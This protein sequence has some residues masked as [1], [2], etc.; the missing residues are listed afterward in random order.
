MTPNLT[1]TARFLRRLDAG[2]DAWH[3]RTLPGTHDNKR[4]GT[5]DEHAA[6]LA[7]E[8]A[9]GRN[10]F[11][12]VNAG[13]QTGKEI[14]RVRAVFA[15]LD[16]SPLGPILA[17]ALQPHIVVASSP[18]KW[19]VYWI[20]DG[21]PLAQFAGVQRAIAARFGSDATVADLPRLMRL[22]GFMHLKGEPFLSRIE[23]LHDA[24]DYSA[25]QL[26]AEFP[27][28]AKTATAPAPRE[29]GAVVEEGRHD[30]MVALARKLVLSG[31]SGA[32][33]TATLATMADAGRWSR[34]MGVG[35]MARAVAGAV[36]KLGTSGF[37]P[38]TDPADVFGHGELPPG[39][40]PI[41]PA[42][43]FKLTPAAELLQTPKPL[44]WL[45]R[46]YLLPGSCSMLVGEPAA[47][48]SLAVIDW[49][50]CIA[51]GRPW[52]GHRTAPGLVI[53]LAGEGQHGI[54]R[55][56]KAWA[57]DNR[58]DLT[59]A[60]IMVSDRGAALND[61]AALRDVVQ[62]IDA[63]ALLYGPP[64]L[65]VSDTLHRNLAGDEN[66]AKD[67][68][69]YFQAIDTL[70][71]RYGAHILTVHHSGHADSQRA[72][73]SSSLRAAVDT[74]LLLTVTAGAGVR[75]L[76]VTKQKDGPKPAPTHFQLKEVDLPWLTDDGQRETSV[77]LMPASAP[78]QSGW[79]L[80]PAQRRALD[81]L[82][83][84]GKG[85]IPLESWRVKF[86]ETSTADS[87]EAKRQAFHRVRRD[88]VAAGVV[89]CRDDR[90]TVAE[91]VEPAT[92]R[93]DAAEVFGASSM[94]V[95]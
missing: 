22:P 37:E 41:S 54:A 94:T 17:C 4:A 65:I 29:P 18:G 31:L 23:R 67:T 2:N 3:F 69:A 82:A 73:G 88:L 61:P 90:Y 60:S 72:R 63:A 40:S 62:A 51:L 6:W 9:A 89:T 21:L 81:A 20:V 11:A 49:A 79:Q 42:P 36:G 48:K 44:S 38:V 32:E 7:A 85:E 15:D 47:G 35:E 57:V 87:P 71:T 12:V 10:V 68:A 52:R 33:A 77:V 86:Y 27:P 45:L 58:A 43:R 46:D 25:A 84:C 93:V 55:R 56:L 19:H 59:R 83:Q 24:P 39:A 95:H 16:G 13:G 53:Y 66:S 8:N 78:K 70:R 50:A 1:D 76:A 34:E 75:T 80:G 92:R 28:I 14:V 26:L 91:H 30:D 64:V 74:E 5:L